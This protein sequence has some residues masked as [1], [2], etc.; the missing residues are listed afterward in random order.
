[1]H[2]RFFTPNN[3]ILSSMFYKDLLYNRLHLNCLYLIYFCIMNA[4]PPLL[5]TFYHRCKEKAIAFED[6]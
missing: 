4:S 3:Y 1:M 2:I 6:E 5:T